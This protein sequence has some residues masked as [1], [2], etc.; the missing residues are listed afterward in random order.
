MDCREWLVCTPEVLGLPEEIGGAPL[1]AVLSTIVIRDGDLYEASG[2]LTMGLLGGDAPASRPVRDGSVA[3]RIVDLDQPADR[4]A[5][6]DSVQYVLP[7]P[8]GKLALLAEF[9]LPLPE[10]AEVFARIESLMASF[11]WAA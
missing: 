3:Q 9:Q 2:V 8:D 10:D 11:R 7:A 4:G 6:P 1:L 5:R